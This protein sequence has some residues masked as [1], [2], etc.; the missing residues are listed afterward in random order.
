MEKT[1]VYRFPASASVRSVTSRNSLMDGR[2]T[3]R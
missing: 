2:L 1:R 3:I